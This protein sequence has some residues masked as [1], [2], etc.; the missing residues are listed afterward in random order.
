MVC[1][2]PRHRRA[3]QFA[4]TILALLVL[5][6]AP[7]ALAEDGFIMAIDDLPL[8]PGLTE[9]REAGLAFD[10]PQGR[11]VEAYAAGA[12]AGDA[13]EA[14]YEKTLP[15]LGWS[16]AISPAGVA[17]WHRDGE[18]LR[19]DVLANEGPVMVRFYLTPN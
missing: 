1:Q 2:L 3:A 12:V 15:Q 14:F 16:M 5:A 7:A 10:K 19:V 13:V 17:R 11:I 8:M 18:V 4:A 6:A 9:M